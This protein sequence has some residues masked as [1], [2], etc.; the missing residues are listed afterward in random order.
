MGLSCSPQQFQQR[1]KDNWWAG[2]H[3]DK[4]H[5]NPQSAPL[6]RNNSASSRQLPQQSRGDQRWESDAGWSG[7]YSED[8]DFNLVSMTSVAT[9]ET[10]ATREKQT[11][12]TFDRHIN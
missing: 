8:S 9:S 12:G 3:S 10:S 11:E 5:S 7:Y 2:Y 6:V 4:C 1:V